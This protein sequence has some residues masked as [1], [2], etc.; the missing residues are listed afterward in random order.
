MVHDPLPLRTTP[1]RSNWTATAPCRT[2]VH[3]KEREKTYVCLSDNLPSCPPRVLP[4][5]PYPRFYHLPVPLQPTRYRHIDCAACYGNEAEI[6]EVFAATFTEG[7]SHA[8]HLGINSVVTQHTRSSSSPAPL[9]HTTPPPLPLL[10]TMLLAPRLPPPCL[11]TTSPRALTLTQHSSSHSPLL[12]P[13]L[14]STSPPPPLLLH[15][16]SHTCTLK[17]GMGS[18]AVTSS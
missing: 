9:P 16:F 4:T 14:S 17:E 2:R 11:P 5:F 3:H 8:R 18:V 13:P 6:G 7:T 15:L 12:P 10:R 1:Q